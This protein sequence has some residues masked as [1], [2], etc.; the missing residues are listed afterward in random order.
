MFIHIHIISMKTNFVKSKM[1]KITNISTNN[2]KDKPQKLFDC[3]FS[4]ISKRI[5]ARNSKIQLDIY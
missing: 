5:M 2:Y 4:L 1:E 3:N